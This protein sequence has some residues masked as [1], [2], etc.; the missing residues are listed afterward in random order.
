MESM[1]K[2]VESKKL[3]GIEHQ[4]Y[5]DLNYLRKLRNRVHIHAVQHD[6]DTDWYSFN[7]QEV[8]LSKKVLFS[9]LSSDFFEPEEKHCTI[10]QYMKV[11]EPIDQ[12]ADSIPF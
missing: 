6:R 4:V 10:I 11:Q 7:D 5:R 8:K 2:K 9:V 1:I 12:L 3:L